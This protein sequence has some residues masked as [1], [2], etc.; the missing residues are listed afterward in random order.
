MQCVLEETRAGKIHKKERKARNNV[1]AK[2]C[3]Q[4]KVYYG[5]PVN[6]EELNRE[7]YR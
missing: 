4:R 5:C 1:F 7:M 3:G 6:E 2:V